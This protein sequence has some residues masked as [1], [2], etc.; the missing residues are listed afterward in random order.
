MTL[1]DAGALAPV[2]VLA[3]GA[4]LIVL[5]DLLGRLGS[6]ALAWLGALV[7]TGSVA[8]AIAIGPGA[9]G[10]GRTPSRVG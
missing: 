3:F 6:R 7:A 9:S 1:A 2:A 8:T 4:C 10:F 5:V